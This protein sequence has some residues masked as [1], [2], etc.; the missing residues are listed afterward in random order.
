MVSTGTVTKELPSRVGD[1][2]KKKYVVI[3]ESSQLLQQPQWYM[4]NYGI[5]TCQNQTVSVQTAM[6]W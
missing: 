6:L 3:L 4:L 1:W 5:E 2:Y